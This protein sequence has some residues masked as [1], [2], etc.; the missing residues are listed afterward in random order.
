[1]ISRFRALEKAGYTLAWIGPLDSDDPT[2]SADSAIY[3]RHRPT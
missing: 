1:V 3:I 2:D